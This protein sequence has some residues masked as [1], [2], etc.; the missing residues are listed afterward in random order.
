M[1]W[2]EYALSWLNLEKLIKIRLVYAVVSLKLKPVRV[3]FLYETNNWYFG[4]N[5]RGLVAQ[6]K[7]GIKPKILSF[8]GLV[9]YLT[10]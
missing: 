2:E 4:H 9:Q 6:N 8:L 7:L 10:N 5:F 1:R 3:R